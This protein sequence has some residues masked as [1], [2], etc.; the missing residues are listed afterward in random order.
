MLTI[1]CDLMEAVHYI[2]GERL[3]EH[4]AAVEMSPKSI[5][6]GKISSLFPIGLF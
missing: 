3:R 4:Q 2:L 1:Q 6:V 5:R